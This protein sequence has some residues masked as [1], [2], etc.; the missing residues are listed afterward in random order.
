MPK[1]TYQQRRTNKR[2]SRAFLESL[3]AVLEKD[4]RREDVTNDLADMNLSSEAWKRHKAEKESFCQAN[5]NYETYAYAVKILNDRALEKLKVHVVAAI[6]MKKQYKLKKI[7][8]CALKL[9][10]KIAWIPAS[11]KA[12]SSWCGEIRRATAPRLRRQP[13]TEGYRNWAN[14]LE[15]QLAN[16]QKVASSDIRQKYTE[17]VGVGKSYKA[18]ESF[19]KRTRDHM[20]I[21]VEV[22]NNNKASVWFK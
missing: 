9:A 16:G 19:S 14:W 2:A 6:K 17:T 15:Q 11:F 13:Q 8:K 20:F 5:D 18:W 7:K 3:V 21:K 12:S 1:L 4:T 10:A 22:T